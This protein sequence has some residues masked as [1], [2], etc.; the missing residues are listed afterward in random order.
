MAWRRDPFY[1][2]QNKEKQM[3]A[4]ILFGVAV[5]VALTLSVWSD[6]RSIEETINKRKLD[7]SLLSMPGDYHTVRKED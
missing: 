4:L 2:Q 5:P 6:V 1:L 7:A 3:S